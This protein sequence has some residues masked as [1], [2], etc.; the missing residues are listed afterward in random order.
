MVIPLLSSINNLPLRWN[1]FLKFLLVLFTLSS[2]LYADTA[3]LYYQMEPA[4][5]VV[6]E[7]DPSELNDSTIVVPGPES[8][9]MSSTVT[10][11]MP[12][13]TAVQTGGPPS[14]FFIIDNSGSMQGTLG[15]DQWGQ[16]FTVSLAFIDTIIS[17]FPKAEVGIAVFG[18]H[19]YYD[20]NDDPIFV[21]CPGY[22]NGA[23][24]PF[25][26]VD[27]T[28]NGV[29]GYDVLK[30]YLETDTLTNWVDL[31]YQPTNGVLSGGSTNINVGF[32]AAKHAFQSSKYAKDRQFV[33]FLSDGEANTA[34]GPN[35]S[36]NEYVTDVDGIPTTFTVF[37]TSTGVA[38]VNL[39][40]MTTNIQNNTYSNINPQSNIWA[41]QVDTLMQLLLNNVIDIIV[42]ELEILPVNITVNG[43]SDSNYDSSSQ[44]F[45]FEKHFPLTGV[46]T[47][48]DYGISYNIIKD[49]IA[50]NGDTIQVVT[51][52]ATT[53]EFTVVVQ[54]GAALPTHYPNGFRLDCWERELAFYYNNTPVS[55]IS[56]IMQNV[57]IRF[58]YSPGVADYE[59]TAVDV[60]IANMNGTI[61]DL[62][63]YSLTRV[64]T[65]FTGS[66]PRVIIP[67]ATNPTIG[68]G[69]LQHY[70]PD[71]IVATFRNNEDPK[72]P[73]DTLQI[74][75]P[76]VLS[77]YIFIASGY[78][79]D[80]NADGY[81]DSI[82]VKASTDIAGGLTEAHL[83][84]IIDSS[85]IV[86]P[87]YRG[88]TITDYHL[89]GGGFALIV[90]EDKAH[91]PFTYVTDED[92]LTI[93]QVILSVGGWLIDGTYPIYD[94]VAP[95]IHWQV[96]SAHLTD[97]Y[98][99]NISDTLRVKFS[100][101]M[102]LISDSVPFHF[103]SIQ[104]GVQYTAMLGTVSQPQTDS[105]VFYVSSLNGI[106][107]MRDGDSLWIHEGDRVAD[108]CMNETG[109]TAHNFQNNVNNT[110][111]RLYVDQHF[112]SFNII[113]GY[114]FDN[115]ADG[116]V[117]SIYVKIST[118]ISGGFTD[119][120]LKEI[121][122]SSVVLL[123]D[124]RKF[125]INSYLRVTEGF[126]L[127]VDEG[128][129]NPF[130]Y[131]T[132]QDSLVVSQYTFSSG[133]GGVA[134]GT[135]PIIDKIAPLIHWEPKSAYL[136]DY[137]VDTT[138]DTLGVRFS[139][140]VKYVDP[141][142]PFY[143]LSCANATVYTARL[144]PV[145]Q[146]KPDSMVFYVHSLENNTDGRMIDGD[147]LWIH[148][149]DQ[150]G[151]ICLDELG[152]TVHNFQ[153]NTE[154]TRRRL[155][156]EKKL[157]PYELIPNSITPIDISNL[158][159]I[160]TIPQFII[161]ILT[162]QNIIDDLDLS[163]N[164]NGD[165]IGMIISVTP[166]NVDIVLK[167]FTLRGHLTIY[168]AV[169]NQVRKRR[170]MGWD[171][172]HKSLVYVWN[173]KNENLRSVGSAMYLCLI[174]IEEITPSLNYQ[175]GGPKQTK[176]I[177]VGVKN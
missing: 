22:T 91:N 67:G 140:P 117:D 68:D 45:I 162:N 29:S 70:Q 51:D 43:I 102:K 145:R 57:E 122:D 109:N 84:E 98:I 31:T 110:R 86:L 13:D 58:R 104:G 15:M 148:E 74:K 103:K 158:N 136:T 115:N 20:P 89:V 101:P 24:V 48:F 12:T 151:D 80:N 8:V 36:P 85:A 164:I 169:G 99:N 166:D 114:Y 96:K 135:Y 46:S 126:S 131:V 62:E 177:L 21:Q 176:K 90:D 139:E 116:F 14:L 112:A 170:R 129:T 40:N 59:Y 123:P 108:S 50:P 107:R 82:Y 33:I 155:W 53:G 3:F 26:R 175:D 17:L 171:E 143:F 42:Q 161:D 137:Q 4:C 9:A 118:D 125:T 30:K 144:Y 35:T 38:P 153:N 100:E 111:R 52:S 87:A 41:A 6:Y 78:Y 56:E 5:E 64:D 69:T 92:K 152:N 128:L 163:T 27:S 23:Y 10:V 165:L 132:V 106:D 54:D 72:L 174:E 146:P 157:I 39:V 83:Q 11:D 49:S 73:L 133:E 130:T 61:Q 76:F 63:T 18:T 168:D 16:R 142:V 159:N 121:M 1:T 37:F 19:L 44:T 47:D 150:I 2:F 127:L 94:K 141:G 147:S 28:Y 34:N 124:L 88:F 95:L 120:H 81:V 79:Y 105:M 7:G 32:A 156:V 154:N 66:F 75:A 172:Q 97:Y 25:L 55:F 134:A 77:G 113:C 149:G 160:P 65:V 60:E 167:D 138:K 119:A 173:A 71:T 93:L